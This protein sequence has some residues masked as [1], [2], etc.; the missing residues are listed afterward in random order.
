MPPCL[1]RWGPEGSSPPRPLILPASTSE[2]SP[3]NSS[4]AAGS[5]QFSAAN[6]NVLEDVGNATITVIRTG[7]SKGTLSVNYS[8]A[9]ITALAGSDYTAVSGGLVFA[10]GELS[11]TFTIPVN[12]DGISEPD[13]TLRLA[14]SGFTNVE[15]M[16]VHSTATV[17]IQD[18]S[19]P[20]VLTMDSIDVVEGNSGTT[21][22]VVTA[23][24]SAATGRT[25]T[26]N[27]GPASITA[28][29]GVDFTPVFGSLS[30]APG[31]TAQT[32]SV[33][34]IGDVLNEASETFQI[35]LTSP[36][37]ASVANASL[38]RIIN[39]DPLPSLSISNVSV[40]EG[41]SG[42]AS[43]VFNVTLSAPS[44]RPLSVVYA[45]V[46]GTAAAA[47]DYTATSEGLTFNSGETVQTVSV[48]V[49][50]DT[51]VEP[52]ETFFV[53]LLFPTNATITDSQGIGIIAND[54]GGAGSISFSQSNYTIGESVGVINI[55]VNRTGD[56][57]GP[58]TVDY[59][60]SDDTAVSLVPPLTVLPRLVAISR[61]PWAHCDL[62]PAKVRRR[63]RF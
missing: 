25:V 26:A 19:T 3:C 17:T 29:S 57:S 38:V 47:S 46:N 12:N 40:N 27:F 36:T 45:T 22:A 61:L 23:S 49:V 20:L 2:F 59:A 56:L 7:G 55:T 6:Y 13:E 60:T 4:E 54:D 35:F 11:K 48:E 33:P 43:A 24:L 21:N 41:S 53:N 10:E 8:S 34:I 39:D 44:G 28:T 50:G 62:P 31:V 52:D 9:D 42:T 15:T 18:A 30:F 63:S 5:I 16:G 37:N 58:A 1:S 51:G 32:I 14:L